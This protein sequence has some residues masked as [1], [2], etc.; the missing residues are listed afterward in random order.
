MRQPLE[1]EE[2]LYRIAQEALNNVVKHAQAR[3]VRI[4]L[5][6]YQDGSHLTVV[7]DFIC[8]LLL[9]FQYNEFNCITLNYTCNIMNLCIV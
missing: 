1:Q 7:Y 4:R 6:T 9:E 8:F 5:L 2:A 3:R